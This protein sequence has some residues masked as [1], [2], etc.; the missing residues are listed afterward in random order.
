MESFCEQI[1]FEFSLKCVTSC[2]F[3]DTVVK[4]IPLFWTIHT[5]WSV[6]KSASFGTENF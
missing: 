5:E 2:T 6:S 1:C 4:S 3:F